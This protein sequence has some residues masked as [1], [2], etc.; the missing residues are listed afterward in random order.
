VISTCMEVLLLL[1]PVVLVSGVCACTPPSVMSVV[2]TVGCRIVE[3]LCMGQL[4]SL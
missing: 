1:F 3:S 2:Y 4:Y